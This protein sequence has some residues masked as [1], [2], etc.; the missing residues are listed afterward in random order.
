[1]IRGSHLRS[2]SPKPLGGRLLLVGS[3]L[4]GAAADA[5]ARR[6]TFARGEI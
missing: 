2:R 4:V 6:A 3:A 1:M 5:A